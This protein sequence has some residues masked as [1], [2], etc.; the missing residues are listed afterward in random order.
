MPEGDANEGSLEHIPNPKNEH[1]SP[2]IN[3]VNQDMCG[4]GMAAASQ[5]GLQHNSSNKS[6]DTTVNPRIKCHS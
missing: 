1:S 2:V 4:T 6:D 3:H 5:F